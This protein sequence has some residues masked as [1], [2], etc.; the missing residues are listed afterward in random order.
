MPFLCQ[1]QENNQTQMQSG[2]TRFEINKKDLKLSKFL[3]YI[4]SNF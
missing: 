4:T 1:N 3:G 2:I